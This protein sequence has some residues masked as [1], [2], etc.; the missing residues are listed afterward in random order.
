MKQKDI[1][2]ILVVVI[3]S[4]MASFF[5]A[6]F[7]FLSGNNRNTQYE[8]VEPITTQFDVPNYFGPKSIDP[9]QLIEIGDG[10]NNAP[11]G[12]NQP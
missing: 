4:G 7:L 8:V 5:L 2:L 11:Y 9:T 12:S 3:V 10:T 1:G 6:R